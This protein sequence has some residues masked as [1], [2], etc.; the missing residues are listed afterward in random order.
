MSQTKYFEPSERSIESVF[1]AGSMG[2]PI[3][4]S[5][6]ALKKIWYIDGFQEGELTE[7]ECTAV[8]EVKE[9]SSACADKPSQ[10]CL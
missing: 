3:K 4:F 10:V 1:P 5:C 8:E 2:E 9:Y 7:R 6:L